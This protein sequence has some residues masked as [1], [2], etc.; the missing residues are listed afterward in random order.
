MLRTRS[1]RLYAAICFASICWVSYFLFSC[2]SPRTVPQTYRF[3][4]GVLWNDAK[5]W[6]GGRKP[7]DSVGPLDTVVVMKGIACSTRVNRIVIQGVLM[8]NGTLLNDGPLVIGG[9]MNVTNGGGNGITNT[10]TI[11][12]KG[13]IAL[14][15]GIL[16]MQW[17]QGTLVNW[18]GDTI[19]NN[20]EMDFIQGIGFFNNGVFIN[21]KSGLISIQKSGSNSTGSNF[22]NRGT[23]QIQSRFD[24]NGGIFENY[25]QVVCS[26]RGK[27]IL[28]ANLYNHFSGGIQMNDTSIFTI[29]KNGRLSNDGP[30][31]TQ[32]NA[33]LE[34]RGSL[35]NY[36]YIQCGGNLLNTGQFTQ[37]MG[38]HKTGVPPVTLGLYFSDTVFNGNFFDKDGP[39]MV[40]SGGG[41]VINYFNATMKGYTPNISYALTSQPRNANCSSQQCQVNFLVH[42]TGS[43][44]TFQW[45]LSTDSGKTW[46]LVPSGGNYYAQ[47][48][49]LEITNPP[50][51]WNG[52]QYRCALTGLGSFDQATSNAATLIMT[53]DQRK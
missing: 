27:L 16:Y 17:G 11:D 51:A 21:Q 47:G 48:G 18:P 10:N 7:P 53:G 26:G 43:P 40:G 35:V 6:E 49:L 28:G 46:T 33:Y 20:T 1:G 13:Q 8:V 36:N 24:I 34:N 31:A 37:S 52:Y 29:L 22:Q 23:V 42:T 38:E 44:I 25:G 19:L 15:S 30:L 14:D 9:K 5:N 12:N 2:K 32:K 3:V 4:R 45:Q 39:P 41:I 50:F